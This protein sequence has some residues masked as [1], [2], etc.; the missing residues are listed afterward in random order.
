MN[1]SPRYAT[2]QDYVRVLRKHR[3]LIAA[4]TI[5]AAVVTVVYSLS[6]SKVYEATA[7][8]AFRDVLADL[9]IFS[10]DDSVPEIAPVTRAT[11]NAQTLTRPEVTSRVRKELDTELSSAE[12][13]D[14]IS[15]QVN[16]QT[17]LVEVTAE[18]GDAEFAADLA[19]AYAVAALRVGTQ[20]ELGRIRESAKIL[21]KQI[22]EAR[23]DLPL[24][25]FQVGSLS[26]QLLRVEQLLENAEPVSIASRATEPDSPI[27]PRPVRNTLLGALVGLLVGLLAA[28]VRDALDRRVRSPHDV[29]HELGKPVLG[30]VSETAFGYHGLVPKDG[31]LMRPEDFEAF[32]V[33]RTNL[34]YL[35]EGGPRTL[36][37]TSAN[38][39][40]GKSTV[41]VAIASAAAVN[42]QSVLLV[43]TDLRRA[44]FARRLGV[45]ATPG[46]TDY[47]MGN[48]SPSEIL[49][50]VK[51]AEPPVVAGAN[52]GAPAQPGK[53]P[54][55][56]S[57]V[58]IAA[59]TP[60][61]TAAELLGGDRFRDFMNKVSRAYDFVVLDTSPMLAVADPL[62]LASM[63]D[64]VLVCVRSDRTTRDQVRATREILG[65]LPDLST[66]AVVTGLKRNDPDGHGYYYGY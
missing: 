1:D 3:I 18:A 14:S 54:V 49:Q 39:E 29:N 46:L 17:T 15:T 58:C 40:E 33:L 2:L 8:L 42:G 53:K 13:A 9:D 5:L 44:S 23:E 50:V 31:L 48:A 4:I 28:F 65:H 34:A 6:Q 16:V 43:E 51:L 64:T 47:L 55:A 63:V 27:S 10:G 56:K 21:R 7:D 32:R 35:K 11:I 45:K 26:N 61:A 20:F 52:G 37:V 41:S 66:G 24:S 62:Q 38:A 57:L 19:N 30:R 60:A 25:A 22:D 36:L 12:L 59:G